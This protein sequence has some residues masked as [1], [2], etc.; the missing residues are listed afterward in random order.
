MTPGHDFRSRP[1]I[2]TGLIHGIRARTGARVWPKVLIPPPES[3]QNA[4]LIQDYQKHIR[5]NPDSPFISI[6]AY[7][8]GSTSS[9]SLSSDEPR[10]PSANSVNLQ[11]L[12]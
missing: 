3:G 9:L 4:R 1:R 7:F 11:A 2:F 5:E 6:R 12:R 10:A 8:C